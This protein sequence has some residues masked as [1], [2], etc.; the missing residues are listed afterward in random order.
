[1]SKTPQ[2]KPL[3]YLYVRPSSLSLIGVGKSVWQYL[4]WTT[5]SERSRTHRLSWTGPS[6]AW[7]YTFRLTPLPGWPIVVSKTWVDTPSPNTSGKIKS[8]NFILSKCLL[9]QKMNFYF[10]I[11]L[12]KSNIDHIWQLTSGAR[13]LLWISIT[14]VKNLELMD[15][16]FYR[17]F[18]IEYHAAQ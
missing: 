2:Q 14:L 11:R 16:D 17:N 9:E 4:Q 1:M 10:N 12:Y 5:Y 6:A 7:W 3:V 13:K 8:R 18:C 15:I